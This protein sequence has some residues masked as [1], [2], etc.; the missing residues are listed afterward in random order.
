[1]PTPIDVILDP[2]SLVFIFTFF[3]LMLIESMFP[4]EKMPHIAFWRAKG[5]IA[6][7]IYFFLASYI[8]LL[9]DPFLAQYQLF[10][11]QHLGIGW[12]LLVS[13]VVF[14]F[15]L[16]FWHRAMHD[17][18][19]L[20]RVFHQFHHSAERVDMAGAYYFNLTD[21][22]GFTL[23]GS[24]CLTLIIGVSPEVITIFLITSNFL[25]VF[26]HANLKTPRWLGYIIHRP[27]NHTVHHSN[28]VHY[29]NFSD[30]PVI[31]ALFGTFENPQETSG[32]Y[33]FY[34]GASKRMLDMLLLK[35]IN[36]SK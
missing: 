5:I 21:M 22:I 25:A 15:G 1:M 31:D 26:Q 18:D 20:W 7:I 33:G 13:F 35:D 4:R 16:Y 3:L 12:G 9:I 11:L 17:S 14:E 19:F 32:S 6:F 8:P 24:V 23:L 30:F 27:E 10:S 36:K 28:K 34:P 29:K 2:I